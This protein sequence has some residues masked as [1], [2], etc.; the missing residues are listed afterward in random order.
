MI[1][2][3]ADDKECVEAKSELYKQI[4]GQWIVDEKI[5]HRQ[6]SN[7]SIYYTERPTREK[8]H[9]QI[10]QMRYSGEPGWVNS[11]AASKRRPNMNGVNPCGE[12]LV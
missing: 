7:N 8:L 9:W 1:L 10:Q 4:D 2:I 3:D 6:M 11:E 12:I 5:I